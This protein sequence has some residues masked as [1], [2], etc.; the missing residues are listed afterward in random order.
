MPATKQ[1]TV[2]RQS[3]RTRQ[4]KAPPRELRDLANVGPA[5]LDDFE[6][7]GIRTLGDLARCDA[8]HLY[9]ALCAKTGQRQDPC[10]IDV[11]LSAID[12]ARGGP[13]DPWWTFTDIRK[14]LCERAGIA[15]DAEGA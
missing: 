13:P 1:R 3:S 9:R 15:V 14:E 4:T 11:F 8:F 5:T 12:Q 7:L 6:L 2:S 10:V